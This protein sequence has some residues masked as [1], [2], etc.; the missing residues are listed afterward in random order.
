MTATTFS[1][2]ALTV[3]Y[4]TDETGKQTGVVIPIEVWK[5]I[6][7]VLEFE[8]LKLKLKKAFQDVQAIEKGELPVVTLK[9]FLN[10]H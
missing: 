4:L 2:D 1:I 5:E 3:N 8:A 9:Q 7:I 10:E 6:K